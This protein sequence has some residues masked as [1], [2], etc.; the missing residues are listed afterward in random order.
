[1]LTPRPP[2]PP[3]ILPL[4][5]ERGEGRGEE[6]TPAPN[7]ASYPSVDFPGPAAQ[8]IE[9]KPTK[10]TKSQSRPRTRSLAAIPSGGVNCGPAPPHA[11]GLVTGPVRVRCLSIRRKQKLR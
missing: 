2:R 4:L 7:Q 5:L 9:Q 10:R 8:R 1:R 6:S 11:E 3:R